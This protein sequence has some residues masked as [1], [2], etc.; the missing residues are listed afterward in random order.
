MRHVIHAATSW[1]ERL[2]VNRVQF[3]LQW[4]KF[5]EDELAIL[6]IYQL[7]GTERIGT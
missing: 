2:V 6:G 7:A 3:Y 4:R 5:R 1:T